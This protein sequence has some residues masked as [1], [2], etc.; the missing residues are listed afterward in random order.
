VST[1]IAV[2]LPV[3]DLARSARFFAELGLAKNEQ[4]PISNLSAAASASPRS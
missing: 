4:V 3:K 2:N 1:K